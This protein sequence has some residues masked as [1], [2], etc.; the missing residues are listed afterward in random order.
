MTPRGFLT[1]PEVLKIIEAR[2][3]DDDM[4]MQSYSGITREEAAC[5]SLFSAI[6]GR[7]VQVYTVSGGA[8]VQIGGALRND[9]ALEELVDGWSSWLPSGRVSNRG[10]YAGCRIF[11]KPSG[12]RHW[13]GPDPEVVP[14]ATGAAGRPTPKHLVLAEHARRRKANETEPSRT[15]EAARLEAWLKET[16]PGAPPLKAKS[17][18]NLLPKDFRPNGPFPK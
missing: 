8:V 6:R 2:I 5:H 18:L 4:M 17:I 11:I 14:I 9:S 10:M 1:I 16:Y 12:L 15:K 3:D 7:K 13:L